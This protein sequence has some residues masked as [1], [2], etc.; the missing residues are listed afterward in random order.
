MKPMRTVRSALL[1]AT[2]LLAG[3]CQDTYVWPN[4]RPVGP[5]PPDSA[6]EERASA[7][8][9]SAGVIPPVEGPAES[10]AV[11]EVL[12]DRPT[13]PERE[14]SASA[15][16]AVDRRPFGVIA[17]AG[18]H[19]QDVSGNP[20]GLRPY[21]LDPAQA[22]RRFAAELARP[23]D[24]FLL[25]MP[26]GW[27]DN[28]RWSIVQSSRTIQPWLFN[29]IRREMQAWKA[30]R[31]GREWYVYVGGIL[32]DSA[33]IHTEAGRE[34]GA[35]PGEPPDVNSTV[36]AAL[37]K[38]MVDEWTAAGASRIYVDS[39]AKPDRWARTIPM[40]EKFHEWG[41][42]PGW[43][44]FPVDRQSRSPRLDMLRLAPALGHLRRLEHLDP[45]LSWRWPDDIEIAVIIERPAEGIAAADIERAARLR[46][47]QGCRLGA[48]ASENDDLVRRVVSRGVEGR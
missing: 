25:H 36:H 8:E 23:Y 27:A 35:G 12:G 37:V 5:I 31:P 13:E 48:I 15:R 9:E 41:A 11:Q 39:S 40:F 2:M 17:F 18:R 22:R 43:E 10:G 33:S 45:D 20:G 44:A 16:Y 6:P 3:G 19:D 4:S 29:M 34:K 30:A 42:V 7:P 24:V 46:M 21:W 38:E 14:S 26:A 1:S 28:E 47:A 32:G